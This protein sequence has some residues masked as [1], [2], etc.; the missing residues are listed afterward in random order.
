MK[1]IG[2]LVVAVGVAWGVVAFNMETSVGS[3]SASIYGRD[4]IFNLDLA[5]RRRTHLMI[6]GVLVV[7]GTLLF[8]FGSV[9]RSEQS[10]AGQRKCPFCAESVLVE[11][12]LCKHCGKE[13]PALKIP[14]DGCAKVLPLH[15]AAWKGNWTTVKQLLLEGA[16]VNLVDPDGKTALDFARARGDKQIASLLLS[17][18]AIEHEAQQ[19]S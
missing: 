15:D 2:A 10:S 19:N 6:S 11:A 17:H 9:R 5:E 14:A 4:R 13:L 16:D 8:G 7:V 1:K 3:S 18:G 12:R